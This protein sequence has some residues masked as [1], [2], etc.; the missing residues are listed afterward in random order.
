MPTHHRLITRY[1][2]RPGGRLRLRDCDPAD[3][4]GRDFA[5]VGPGTVKDRAAAFLEANRAG[6]AH[7]Q[8][9]L[10]ASNTHS[11]L[12]VLQAMDA[13]GKDGTIKHVMCGREPAGLRGA[14]VQGARAP[15][16]STTTSCGVACASVP[17]ARPDRHLQP[18][19]L[20]GGARRAR[21]PARSSRAA[22]PAGARRR[23]GLGAS[24]SRTSTRFE[25]YLARNGTVD[26][27]VLPERLARRSRRSASS[28]GST[29]PRRTGSSPRPTSRSAALGRV[30]GRVPGHAARHQHRLGAVVRH[31]GRPQVLARAWSRRS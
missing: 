1:Q 11:V 22:A 18:L 28:S 31:A 4:G 24:A 25:R 20:R 27:Q 10:W 21:A 2:V 8:E 15:R 16:S 13:A 3:S 7:A 5:A 6:L 30:H 17:R 19:V 9:L 29:S 23:R 26:R 12:V 14:L